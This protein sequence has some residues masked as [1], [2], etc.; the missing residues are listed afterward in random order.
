MFVVICSKRAAKSSPPPW[1]NMAMI[2]GLSGAAP[3]AEG[4][5]G[6]SNLAD[7]DEDEIRKSAELEQRHWWYAG[8]RALVRQLVRGVP[9]GR[10]LD[11]GCGSAG[12]TAVLR[13]I[14]WD[15][16]GLEYSPTAAALARARGL[17]VVRGDARRLPFPDA[18]FD[19]VMST[20]MWE[21]IEE[22]DEVAAEAARV[23]RPGGRLLV[24][25][26]A[27]MDLWSGHDLALGHVRRYDRAGLTSL[28]ESV[29]LE[30]SAV[31]SWNVLLR[32]VAR[33]RRSKRQHA[34]ASEMEEVHP[35][36]NAGLR[37]VVAVESF[38]PLTQRRGISLVLRARKPS[39]PS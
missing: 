35:I 38:L 9:L 26:P 19:L 30:V 37:A 33:L 10:A 5:C 39:T 28:V 6:C 20:D 13:D 2:L 34:S 27:G 21:H 18:T 8:R 31:D 12:N 3:G 7:V 16:T 4:P 25:V 24:A 11:V 15:V 17:L 14:G 1:G 29:G 32:P 36:V 23:L 22:D